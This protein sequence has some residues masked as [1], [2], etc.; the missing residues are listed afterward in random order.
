MRSPHE[1]DQV[2]ARIKR[3]K[4]TFARIDKA[5]L[6]SV[7]EFADPATVIRAMRDERDA[8]YPELLTG[9]KQG[10]DA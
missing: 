3:R 1:D 7:G 2:V 10:E 5:P 9:A 8:A 4:E 6:P